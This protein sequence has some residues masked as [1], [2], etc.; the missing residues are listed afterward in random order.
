MKRLFKGEAY[1]LTGFGI[2]FNDIMNLQKNIVF[3]PARGEMCITGGVAK[4]NR[5]IKKT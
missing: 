1:C 4:R 3:S 2:V 5:R